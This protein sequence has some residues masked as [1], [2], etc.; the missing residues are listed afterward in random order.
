MNTTHNY[1]FAMFGRIDTYGTEH[2]LTPANEQATML[3]TQLKAVIT[4]MNNAI[5]AQETG[6]AEELG[7]SSDR[8]RM[9]DE[10]SADMRDVVKTA[11]TLDPDQFPGIREEF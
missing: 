8:Q 9:A 4:D 10:L 5:Q 1:R 7:A 11:R 6:F 3:F 2:P